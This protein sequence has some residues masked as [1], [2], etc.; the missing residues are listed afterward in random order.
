MTNKTL[1]K[2]IAAQIIRL[3]KEQGLSQEELAE[4][5]DIDSSYLGR[6]ERNE[7]RF[8]VNTAEKI[9]TGLEVTPSEFF[10]F[11]KLDE[12]TSEIFDLLTKINASKK[13]DIMLNIIKEMLELT[14]WNN[15]LQL[16]TN[17]FTSLELSTIIAYAW[18]EIMYPRIRN[19]REDN[20]LTQQDMA[21]TL[22]ISQTTYSRYESGTLDIPTQSLIKLAKY[23]S[24]SVDYLL[25]ITDSKKAYPQK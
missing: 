24:T 1:N 11:L 7:V 19:L 20:D 25:G 14:E 22:N 2:Q 12:S 10:E 6:V 3:R 23:Y 13:R 5:A 8:T 21:M 18:G 17:L 16:I 15:S 9:I 4:K